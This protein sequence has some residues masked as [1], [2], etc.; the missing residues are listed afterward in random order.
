MR[1][2]KTQVEIKGSAT[3]KGVF[4]QWL[5]PEFLLSHTPFVRGGSKTRKGPIMM[6][7]M[8]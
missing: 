4:T 6:S 5:I 2:N 7:E 3:H 1:W 8:K